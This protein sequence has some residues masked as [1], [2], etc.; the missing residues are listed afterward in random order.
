M[1]SLEDALQ[2]YE[3]DLI[4]EALHACKGN[5]SQAARLLKIPTPTLR[6]KMQKYKLD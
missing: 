2:R 5:K 1:F 4:R 6:Y 3:I